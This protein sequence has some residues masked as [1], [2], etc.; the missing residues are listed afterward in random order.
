MKKAQIK[1]GLTF[2]VIAIFLGI[3]FASSIGTIHSAVFVE[4]NGET[5]NWGNIAYYEKQQI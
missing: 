3:T 2:G 4:K 1:K 5:Y